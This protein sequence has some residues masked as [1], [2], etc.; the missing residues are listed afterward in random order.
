MK[1]QA[2]NYKGIEFVRLSSLPEDQKQKIET[3]FNKNQIIKILK[4]SEL[5]KDCIQYTDYNEW[6]TKYFKLDKTTSPNKIKRSL[7]FPHS[8][9][10]KRVLG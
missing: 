5:L 3:T 4:D 6:Y 7:L 1:L 9:K 2:E 10:A 8:S